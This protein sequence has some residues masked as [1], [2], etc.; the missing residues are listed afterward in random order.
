MQE[1]AFLQ[2]LQDKVC[3]LWVTACLLRVLLFGILTSSMLPP[4][5]SICSA[6]GLGYLA[7]FNKAGNKFN[8]GGP[9][10]RASI[11]QTTR[12]LCAVHLQS[13]VNVQSCA[14]PHR[15]SNFASMPQLWGR[16]WCGML[17]KNAAHN[18]QL[19]VQLRLEPDT[20]CFVFCTLP[21]MTR[22]TGIWFCQLPK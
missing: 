8:V 16:T 15:F 22:V 3:A 19:L 14:D 11:W 6:C 1:C 21:C 7:W 20:C 10:D 4:Q 9:W 17:S 5:A 13:V 18:R 2:Q 12:V